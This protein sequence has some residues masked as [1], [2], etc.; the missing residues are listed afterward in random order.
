[1]KDKLLSGAILIFALVSCH[2][3]AQEKTYFYPVRN[4]VP[5]YNAEGDAVVYAQWGERLIYQ[6]EAATNAQ[7]VRFLV[8]RELDRTIGYVASGTVVYSPVSTG[9]ILNSV[10]LYNSPSSVYASEKQNVYPPILVYVLEIHE[11]GW[12]KIQPYVAEDMYQLNSDYSRILGYKWV[13][14][15]KISTNQQD[16]D[17]IVAIQQALASVRQTSPS[18]TNLLKQNIDTQ[19]KFLQDDITRAYRDSAA[20]VYVRDAL[21]VLDGMLIVSNTDPFTD[22]GSFFDSGSYEDT[23]KNPARHNNDGYSNPILDENL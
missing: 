2:K 21:D 4:N 19:M 7:N 11:D 17:V 22:E 14:I 16:V 20:L 8:Q 10:L 9:V 6:N 3:T 13:L 15:D 23:N 18:E 1:M 12:A 5:I